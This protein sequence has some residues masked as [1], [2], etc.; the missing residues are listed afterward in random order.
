[1][2]HPDLNVASARLGFQRRKRVAKMIWVGCLVIAE[3]SGL[4]QR[5]LEGVDSTIYLA[6]SPLEI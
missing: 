5:V 6:D 1:M 3:A 4:E 2:F